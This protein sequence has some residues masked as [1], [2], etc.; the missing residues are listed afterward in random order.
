MDSTKF[1]GACEQRPFLLGP[2]VEFPCPFPMRSLS[3]NLFS[4]DVLMRYH[5]RMTVG[6]K[7]H[8]V[9]FSW[10]PRVARSCAELIRKRPQSNVKY[11]RWHMQGIALELCVLPTNANLCFS[12]LQSVA[13]TLSCRF[14]RFF[15][16]VDE[17]S[18]GFREWSDTI[19]V[20]YGVVLSRGGGLPDFAPRDARWCTA[21][22]AGTANFTGLV[23]GCIE[24][25]FCKKIC[26]WK[27]SP[28]STQC[29]PLHS[30]AIS[31][32]VKFLPRLLLKFCKF[33]KI[34]RL[35]SFFKSHFFKQIIF[36]LFS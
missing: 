26:V 16:H 33:G 6:S 10:S 25:K 1:G 32:F 9:D 24:T 22:P 23:L 30:S 2:N 20:S 12:N 18:S 4:R 31:F 7:H 5:F 21:P 11:H 3:G 19:H 27:L 8:S 34:N 13:S 29:T 35:I 14:R 17:F 36:F 15:A 28:R